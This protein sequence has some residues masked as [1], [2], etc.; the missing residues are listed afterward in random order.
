[1]AIQDELRGML[2]SGDN[3]N[4]LNA[5]IYKEHTGQQ[6][7]PDFIKSW[8]A[9]KE[10]IIE[11]LQRKL[12]LSFDYI[13]YPDNSIL[14]YLKPEENKTTPK[15][16]RPE[17]VLDFK[18][19]G[20]ISFV[21]IVDKQKNIVTKISVQAKYNVNGEDYNKRTLE[22]IAPKLSIPDLINQLTQNAVTLSKNL[23]IIQ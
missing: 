11:N 1:M 22:V 10:D 3:V 19:E 2:Y 14:I 17:D 9:A 23:N 15:Q 6:Y 7:A 18:S 16:R 13:I 21:P 12:P 20:Q 4:Y 8:K 5:A